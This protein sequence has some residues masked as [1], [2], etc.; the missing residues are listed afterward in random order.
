[1]SRFYKISPKLEEI[2]NKGSFS[3]GIYKGTSLLKPLYFFN[4]KPSSVSVIQDPS[5]RMKFTDFIFPGR[6]HSVYGMCFSN[7]V[8][9]ILQFY[10]VPEHLKF[11]TNIKKGNATRIYHVWLLTESAYDGIELNSVVLNRLN[12]ITKEWRPVPSPQWYLENMLVKGKWDLLPD[13]KEGDLYSR[14]YKIAFKKGFDYDL[15]SL[16]NLLDTLV[17]SEKLKK[18]FENEKISGLTYEYLPDFQVID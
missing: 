2:G 18:V 3:I 5:P 7:R 4:S 1:M 8:R 13:K 14:I 9:E 11:E 10:K 17:V 12:S 16:G 15:F 6:L